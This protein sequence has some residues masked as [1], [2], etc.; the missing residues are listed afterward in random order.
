MSKIQG[1]A[2]DLE[3]TVINIESAH[4]RG[5]LLAAHEAGVVLDFDS[6]LR[7]LPH[8]IGGPREAIAQEIFELSRK[9]LHVC[10]IIEW[11]KFYYKKLLP[12]IEIVPRPGF[13]EILN[14]LRRE[15]V[16]VSI[17]SLTPSDQAELL[18]EKSGLKNIFSQN[19]IILR[20]DV[21]EVKPAPDVFFET[22]L[23]MDVV[24]SHQLV[25]EDSPRGAEAALRAGSQVV[26]MPVYNRLDVISPLI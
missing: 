18:L 6:A 14:T 17:G 12:E 26:G 15:G 2:F 13:V 8:F 16:K 22:A 9:N 5:H 3:G 24:T 19:E 1:I 20:E 21:R 10:K 4:H 7:S 23:L 11:D 25:F